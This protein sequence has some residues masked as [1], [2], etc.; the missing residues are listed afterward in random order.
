VKILAVVGA[1][2]NFVKIA[3]I[4][5]E[6]AAYPYVSTTLVHTGQHYDVEMSEAFFANLDIPRPDVNLKVHSSGAVTQIADIMTRLEPVLEGS[7]PDVIVVVGDVNSTVA[8]ALTGVKL[9]RP[10]A[11]IEAGLRS[12]D[13]SMPEE[14]NRVLT[15]AVSDRLFTTEPAANENLAREGVPAEKV[16]FVGNVMIDTLFR[17][18]ERARQSDVLDRLRLEPGGYAALT[19]HRP[20]NV[21]DEGTLGMLLGAIALIQSEVPVVFPVHPR[22]R[23][24]LGAVTA[25]LPSMP[26]LRLVDPLPYLDFVEL[27]ANARCVLTDSGG[28][29]EETTA[30]R[31]PCL[32]LRHNTER[33]VTVARGTNRVVGT[34][35]DA[36]Y[37]A[38]RQVV[39]GKWPPGELPELWDGKAAARIVRVLL[40]AGR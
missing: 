20:S 7:R 33:P 25:V 29:Q 1:R 38:W 3:P 18:R 23:R 8:A 37:E 28:I 15:D 30:L 24:R 32:T 27:M 14:I 17:Y 21:D 26:G 31:I 39:E 2:P 4:L 10:V 5:A 34:E 40:G 12:F 11:H 35:P 6:L 9:G 13:R 22:S 19:L 36:I 16:H